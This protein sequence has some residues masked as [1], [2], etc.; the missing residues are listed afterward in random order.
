MPHFGCTDSESERAERTVSAGVGITADN[1]TTRLRRAE[2]RADDVYDATFRT[3]KTAQF[4]AEIVA[5]FFHLNELARCGRVADNGQIRERTDWRGW[6]RVIHCC[7]R[8]LRAP[9]G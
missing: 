8:L 3:R 9:N 4:D 7:E 1:R 6:R 5:V 2:L